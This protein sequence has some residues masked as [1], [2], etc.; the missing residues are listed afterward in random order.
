M[1]LPSSLWFLTPHV[2]SSTCFVAAFAWMSAVGTNRS[3]PD[4]MLGTAGFITLVAALLSSIVAAVLI[5]FR[6]RQRRHW[7]WLL[8]HLGGLTP[9]LALAD[10][11]FA[12][13]LA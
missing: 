2:L 10:R 11:W 3:E 9:A 5:L 12:T 1:R 7:P 4:L 8:A 6:Q 13:H